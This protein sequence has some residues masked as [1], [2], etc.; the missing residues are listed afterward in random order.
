MSLSDLS[1]SDIAVLSDKNNNGFGGDGL[2][3]II[4]LF[5]LM[6]MM[7]NGWG[8]G[9]GFGGGGAPWM[10]AGQTNTNNDVQRGFDQAA[11]MGALGDI[12]S[13]VTNG[14]AGVNQALC[15]GFAGVNQTI[16]SGFAGAEIAANGR[17]MA[18]MNQLFGLQ[19]AF[20]QCCCEN[21]A[22]IAQLGNTIISENCADRQALQEGVRDIITNQ[23][24]NTQRILDQICNDKI[25]SKNEKILELQNA[26]NMATLRES[27]TQQ[28]AFIAQGLTQE[29]DQL[30]NRLKN[31]PVPSMPVYGNQPVFTCNGGGCGCG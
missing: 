27:Q 15:G 26:L 8:F 29:V 25:D 13:N 16:N 3:G 17:Q 2:Y 22:G 6:G 24:A 20:Q 23:T 12:G 28:N 30:Y 14:F 19:S 7:N 10:L 5:L 21:R 4:V 9:G 18:N 1:A 31:C 11:V